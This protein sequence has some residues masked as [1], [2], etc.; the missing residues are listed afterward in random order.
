MIT[1]PEAREAFEKMK[2]EMGSELGM[3]TDKGDLP[4]RLNG[5]YG[6]YVGGQMTRK[7]VEMGERQLMNKNK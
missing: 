6:G 1:T 4:S 7:L 3:T 5:L 2:T